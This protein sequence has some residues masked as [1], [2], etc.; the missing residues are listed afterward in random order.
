M[1]TVTDAILR[2]LWV[3]SLA[4]WITLA[5]LVLTYLLAYLALACTG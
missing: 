5:L 1:G 4:A 3:C 2:V